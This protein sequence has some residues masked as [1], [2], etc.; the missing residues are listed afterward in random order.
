MLVR[1]VK[2]D[3]ARKFYET[4]ALRN[5]WYVRQLDR[6]IS[7]QF[8]DRTLMSKN[9]TAMLRKGSKE[10]TKDVITPEEKIKD[11]FILEFLSLK[12]EYSQNDIIGKEE[13]T[14]EILMHGNK[15]RIGQLKGIKNKR[16]SKETWYQVRKW[17][18]YHTQQQRKMVKKKSKTF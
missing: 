2:T 16:V 7:S 13:A 5:G 18:D 12:D 15:F 8:Y 10:K 14:L 4:E 3:E 9:K 17:F 6:Q 11:P 1:R